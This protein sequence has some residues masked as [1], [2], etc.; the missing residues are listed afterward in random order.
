MSIFNA[1]ALQPLLSNMGRGMIHED[2]I[3]FADKQKKQARR[4]LPA[5][6]L[7]QATLLLL[8]PSEKFHSIYSTRAIS[9]SAMEVAQ[10]SSAARSPTKKVPLASHWQKVK[11][12][13]TVY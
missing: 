7:T 8:P 9:S 1:N 3:E 4:F 11:L 5:A 10:V 12:I 13:R 6:E 2:I